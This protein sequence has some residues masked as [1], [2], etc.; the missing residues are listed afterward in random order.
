MTTG[1]VRFTPGCYADAIDLISRGKVDLK[2]LITSTYP[3]TKAS[4]AFVAQHARKDIKIV[5]MNQE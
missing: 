4:D 3:L 5:I 1:T 2:P